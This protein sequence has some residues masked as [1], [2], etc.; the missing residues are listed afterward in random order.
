MPFVPLRFLHA[1]DVRL[2]ETLGETVPLPPRVASVAMDATHAAFERLIAA[3]LDQEVDFVLLAGNTFIESDKSLAARLTLIEGCEQLGG[4]GIRVF[5]LPGPLDPLDAWRRISDLPKNVTL[6]D[7]HQ[8]AGIAVKRD[9]KVIALV[10]GRFRAPDRRAT[11]G[12]H[13][14]L[15]SEARRPVPF[16]IGVSVRTS[17]T[18]EGDVLVG[19]SGESAVQG[20]AESANPSPAES[21]VDAMIDSPVDYLALGG[22]KIRRTVSKRRGIAHD[23]GSTQGTGLGECGPHGATL[24]HV[25]ADETVRCEFIPTASVRWEQFTIDVEASLNRA[26]VWQRCRRA[27]ADLRSEPTENAWIVEWTFRG[28]PWT[29]EALD[30][31]LFRAQFPRELADISGIPPVDAT[32]HRLRIQPS[33]DVSA[34]ASGGDL[35]Q[36]DFLQSVAA[37]R[38]ESGAIFANALRRFGDAD[39]DFAERLKGLLE[40]LDPAV[41]IAEACR[42]GSRIFPGEPAD[43]VT[44]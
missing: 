32:V 13:R 25:D 11:R 5:A 26:A 22:G 41:L 30:D 34:L 12:L 18:E 4:Q 27:L 2:D 10:G 9:D 31:D 23:P 44:R 16:R 19:W 24:V 3:A 14:E 33:D 38:H 8:K 6:L 28:D 36:A 29:I 35:M 21:S 43:G 7:P 39:R 1:A 15:R 37:C 42:V 20:F 40:E 17:N